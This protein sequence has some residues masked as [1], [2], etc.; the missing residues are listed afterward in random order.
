MT[1]QFLC[2][3]DME[4]GEW[5]GRGGMRGDTAGDASTFSPNL[6][7]PMETAMPQENAPGFRPGQT[8][9]RP[10]RS[11]AASASASAASGISPT[12]FSCPRTAPL[13]T[14]NELISNRHE[15]HACQKHDSP[16]QLKY[17]PTCDDSPPCAL[18]EAAKGCPRQHWDHPT[19][20]LQKNP[21]SLEL[22]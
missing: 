16:P 3:G 1:N 10:A 22:N 14:S 18:A 17:A 6:V 15:K 13:D 9:W 2:G 21:G 12:S 19:M 7:A 8:P 5:G 20:P 4:A 11:D